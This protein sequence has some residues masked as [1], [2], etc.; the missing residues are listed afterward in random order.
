MQRIRTASATLLAAVVLLSCNDNNDSGSMSL[1]GATPAAGTIY[2][3]GGATSPPQDGAEPKGTLTAVTINGSPVLFGRTAIGGSN[4]CGIIFSVNPDGSNYNVQYRFGGSD[5]CDPR[6]DAMTFNTN[7]GKLYA[8]TQGV[9]Q[10]NNATYGNQGQ[11]FSF[12]PGSSIPYPMHAVHTFTG[13]PD[14]AQQHSSFSIDPMSGLLYGQSAAG[15]ANNDGLLYA[16]STDGTQFISLHDFKKGTGRDPH[17]RIVLDNGV[18][19][20]ITRSDG[21]LPAAGKYGYGTVFAYKLA[22]PLAN[23]PVSVLHVF[24][25][26]PDDGALSD[27]GYLTPV[28]VGSKTI[29]FGMTQCGGAGTGKSS[30]ASSDGG[31]AGIIFQI[32]PTA[33]P[34]SKEAFSIVY[35][36]QGQEHGDGA[37]PYGSL[38]YDGTYLYGT[39]SD[40]GAYGNGTVFR[41]KPVAFGATATPTQLYQFGAN[42]NDGAK[43]IDNVIRIGSTL[44]GMTVYGGAG[45][46]P[47][48]GTVFAIPLPN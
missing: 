11:I 20:G 48:S 47:G 28:A 9:N 44:Y 24:A 39:T 35:S 6:H 34:G 46:S 31:G 7:D 42:A 15:G 41:F 21:D 33:T 13:H 45:A 18:L 32:D 2:A 30:C 3:F 14:G 26:A 29:F 38:M 12:T 8:T 25:G 27:H 19:Y 17:G 23:G 4:G 36:F 22:S 40:G 43:P 37:A 5:G 1:P 10:N 16:V